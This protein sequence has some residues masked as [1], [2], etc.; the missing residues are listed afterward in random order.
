MVS[1]V[2]AVRTVGLRVKGW[3]WNRRLRR[4]L[5]R[6]G[7]PYSGKVRFVVERWDNRGPL[8]AGVA[9]VSP[10]YD[11][12]GG[13]SF[14]PGAEPACASCGS[15]ELVSVKADDGPRCTGCGGPYFP[16]DR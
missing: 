3:W 1:A 6:C 8:P 4:A 15:V 16:A 12:T 11:E 9:S 7:L 14:K 2:V 10:V 5:R 13:V